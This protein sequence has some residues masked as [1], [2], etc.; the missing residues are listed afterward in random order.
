MN[1]VVEMIEQVYDLPI[2]SPVAA[3]QEYGERARDGE[4]NYGDILNSLIGQ[5]VDVM[6]DPHARIQVGYVIQVAI[7]H[8]IDGAASSP[9]DIYHE[10]TARAEVYVKE[11]PWVF[12]VKEE[13]V[14]LDA[15]GKPKRKKGAKQEEAARIFQEMTEGV[16]PADVRKEVIG[17]FMEELDMSKAGATTYFYNMRKK[18]ADG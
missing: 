13:E 12:A 14:K 16:D 18:F 10:A 15:N 11:N 6:D 7:Q 5:T 3:I 17:A 1:H 2:H 4:F 8:H 9:L